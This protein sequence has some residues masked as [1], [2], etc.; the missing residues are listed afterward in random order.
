MHQ[1][2]LSLGSNMGDRDANLKQAIRFIHSEIGAVSG[3]SDVYETEPWGNTEQDAFLN[4]IIIVASELPPADALHHILAI[5]EK[6]GRKRLLRWGPRLIDIDILLCDDLVIDSPGLIIPHPEMHKRRF[7]LEPIA[8]LSPY[9]IHPVLKK[10]MADLYN[11]L[12]DPLTVQK[13]KLN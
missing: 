2:F 5:E 11:N 1:F 9:K 12:S 7:I 6:M 10:S 13:R 8:Q 3:Q 4:Q